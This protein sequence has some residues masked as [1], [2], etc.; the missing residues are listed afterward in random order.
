MPELTGPLVLPEDVMLIPVGELAA[1]TRARLTCE[2][3]DFAITR[4]R[5]RT[6]SRVV[7]PAFAALLTE[8]RSARTIVDAVVGFSKTRDA[9]PRDVLKN[10][11]P[12]LGRLVD[13]GL[14]VSPTAG[15]ATTITSS[16]E[17]GDRIGAFTIVAHVHLVEDVELYQATRDDGRLAVLKIARPNASSAIVGTLKREADALEHL[18]GDIAPA[19]FARGD[20]DGTPYFAMEWRPGVA[21]VLAAAEHRARLATDGCRSVLDLCIAIADAYAALHARGVLH[22]DV[23]DRNVLVGR[24]GAVTIIDYGYAQVDGGPLAPRAGV[25]QYHDPQFAAA[26]LADVRVPPLSAADE[27]Y[28]IGALL[29]LMAAGVPYVELSLH[30]AE[31]LRQIVEDPP[32]SF[33]SHG[34]GEWPTLERVLARSL[35]KDPTERFASVA[36]LAAA[37]R[38][39]E[40]PVTTPRVHGGTSA[41]SRLV[42]ELIPR[43]T[44]E[45]ADGLFARGFDE[46]PLCSVNNGAAGVAYAF[47]RLAMLRDD[48]ALLAD[49]DA[50]AERSLAWTSHPEA[51]APRDRSLTWESI[52]RV[53]IYHTASG[54]H[55]ARTLVS[56]AA[57][58]EHGAMRAADQYAEAVRFRGGKIDITL[59]QAAALLGCALQVQASRDELP[60]LVRA[61]NRIDKII[62]RALERSGAVSESTTLTTVAIAHGWAGLLYA[63][64]QWALARGLTPAPIVRQRLDEVA[65]L[66]RYTRRGAHWPWTNGRAGDPAAPYFTPGWC[67]GTA[68]FAFLWALAY[69]AYGEPTFAELAESAAWDVWDASGDQMFDLCCGLAGRGYALLALYRQTGDAKWVDRARVLVERAASATTATAPD[70]HRLYKGALG[71][72]L[73]AAELERPELARMPMFESQDWPWRRGAAQR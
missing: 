6:P 13:D 38:S 25:A 56:L 35:A 32:R 63:S 68:G 54:I 16:F 73:L 9:D 55:C 19:L 48:A 66:G 23:H 31:A 28:S 30:R 1:Q 70:A 26:L 29:Y 67:N 59:G 18:A 37:L 45:R 11:F 71:V 50:W 5:S 2:D 47:Y 52:G 39:I 33:A 49:A 15:R 22:G 27:Q 44:P 14:L 21:P 43:L 20:H 61:G 12:I 42:A 36:E 65:A 53:S 24:T 4:P 58:D 7:D 57:S 64:M 62:T 46:M 8:F 40:V 72:A 41:A 3:G 17:I 51:F 34:I 60:A 69:R 10:A